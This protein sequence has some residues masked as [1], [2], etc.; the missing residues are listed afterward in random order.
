[1]KNIVHQENP[2]CD[3]VLV[4]AGTLYASEHVARKLR[5]ANTSRMELHGKLDHYG[6]I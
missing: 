4:F 5:R 2:H 6:E 3:R 1:M